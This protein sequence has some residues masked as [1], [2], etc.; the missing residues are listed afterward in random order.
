QRGGRGRGGGRVPARPERGGVAGGGGAAGADG[1]GHGG[2]ACTRGRLCR[3]PA[4][5]PP[6]AGAGRR[7]PRAAAWH[8]EPPPPGCRARRARRR[9]AGWGVGLGLGAGGASGR[10]PLAAPDP[11]P[12][13]P[14]AARPAGSPP[15]RTVAGRAGNLPLP[16]SSFI[17]RARELEQAAAA[18]GQARVVTLT[19]PGGVGK[20]RLALQV[21]G[22]VAERFD[23][24]GWLCELAPVRDPA[25]VDGAVA[26][27]F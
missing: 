5:Q 18:L 25:G 24:G 3:P 21:A 27:V 11:P 10:P 22:Q 19:G 17:G 20:T 14:P 7:P 8:P 2:G 26:A 1:A 12:A 13:P 16:V 6:C 4:D 15:I 9:G 23:D